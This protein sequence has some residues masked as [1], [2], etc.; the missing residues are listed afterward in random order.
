MEFALRELGQ[1]VAFAKDLVLNTVDFDFASTV[2]AED[3]FVA[4]FNAQSSAYTVI[5]ELAWS[6]SDNLASLWLFL[7]GIWQNDTACS[8]FFSF[9]RLNNDAIIEWTK[10]YISHVEI[11]LVI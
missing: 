8:G 3:D 10:V 5:E 2:F 6:N 11:T 7:G 1:Y 9:E 4:N